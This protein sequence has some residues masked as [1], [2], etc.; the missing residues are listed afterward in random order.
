M[1]TV[2]QAAMNP[3]GQ[4]VVPDALYKACFVLCGINACYFAVAYFLGLWVYDLNGRLEP[5]D[6]VNVWAAGRLVLDGYPAL[7]YD[8]D[9]QRQVEV[10]VLGRDFSGNFA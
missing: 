3:P 9:V 8:W 1:A 6:F 7:A 4:G 2:A 10:A 5:T